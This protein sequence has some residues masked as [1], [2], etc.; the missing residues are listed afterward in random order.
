MHK[1]L[2]KVDNEAVTY[3]TAYERLSPIGERIVLKYYAESVCLSPEPMEMKKI[4]SSAYL[5]RVIK[6]LNIRQFMPCIALCVSAFLIGAFVIPIAIDKEL[7]RI[8]AV[9]EYN[10]QWRAK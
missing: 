2:I 10:A 3:Y 6:R 9:E 8:E 7:H 4:S 1:Y 5:T